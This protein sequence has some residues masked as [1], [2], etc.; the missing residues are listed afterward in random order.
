MGFAIRLPTSTNIFPLNSLSFMTET[1]IK[2]SIWYFVFCKSIQRRWFTS[3]I[4]PVLK[5]NSMGCQCA[6]ICGF[7]ER[8]YTSF[9]SSEYR[10]CSIL[11]RLCQIFV[12]QNIIKAAFRNDAASGTAFNFDN[13]RSKEN[14]LYLPYFHVMNVAVFIKKSLYLHRIQWIEPLTFFVKA[15]LKYDW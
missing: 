2:E 1:T 6:N 13:W 9:T 5:T 11:N 15:F 4:I 7:W 8:I 3:A 10:F 14:L 12:F